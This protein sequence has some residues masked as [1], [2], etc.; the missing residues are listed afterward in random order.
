MRI[1]LILLIFI[2]IS[3]C[4][5]KYEYWDIAKFRMNPHA[6]EDNEKVKMLYSSRGPNDNKKLE[7]YIH[8]IVISQKTGDTVN[9]L[10][11]VNNSFTEADKERV[12]TFLNASN[13]I[14]KMMQSD[15]D[16]NNDLSELNNGK[17]KDIRK[18]ARDPKFDNIADNTFPTVIGVIGFETLHDIPK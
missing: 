5:S 11:T 18:V 7:Y 6:L 8:M 3:G 4:N 9:I 2:L 17:L 12:F 15:P 10:T 16:K 1:Y 13:P 14:T